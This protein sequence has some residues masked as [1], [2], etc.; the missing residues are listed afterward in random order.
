MSQNSET[1]TP[2]ITAAIHARSCRRALEQVRARK[3]GAVSY[4]ADIQHYLFRWAHWWARTLAPLTVVSLYQAWRDYVNA[5]DPSFI[6]V[7]LSHYTP[8]SL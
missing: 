4:P 6:G 3:E 7:V 1:Q 8:P 2:V 5:F